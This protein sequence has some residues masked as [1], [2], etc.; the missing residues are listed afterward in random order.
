DYFPYSYV[1]TS[2]LYTLITDHPKDTFS[3]TDTDEGL[4]ETNTVG[5][6][7]EDLSTES[8]AELLSDLIT[9][10]DTSTDAF[11]LETVTESESA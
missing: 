10:A 6:A 2:I 9:E 5:S 8:T 4:S 3:P 11:V 7:S 1:C